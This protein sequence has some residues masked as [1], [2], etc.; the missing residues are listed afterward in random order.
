M[1]KYKLG[2]TIYLKKKKKKRRTGQQLFL[3]AIILWLRLI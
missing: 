3:H 2:L 1:L